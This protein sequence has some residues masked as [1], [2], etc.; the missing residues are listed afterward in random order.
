M[1]STGA[2]YDRSGRWAYLEYPVFPAVGAES[3][4]LPAHLTPIFA[5]FE[6]NREFSRNLLLF[7]FLRPV[8]RLVTYIR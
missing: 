1:S 2:V 5:F 4:V 7:S 8:F 3:K 6:Y